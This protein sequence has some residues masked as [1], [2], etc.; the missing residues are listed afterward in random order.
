MRS[1]CL[2]SHGAA[3]DPLPHPSLFLNSFSAPFQADRDQRVAAAAEATAV[4]R[5]SFQEEI[6]RQRR[7]IEV[8]VADNLERLQVLYAPPKTVSAVVGPSSFLPSA[9]PPLF[10]AA[11][12]T[13]GFGAAGS[14]STP[15]ATGGVP[16]PRSAP[17]PE[18][19]KD[20]VEKLLALVRV[21]RNQ[22]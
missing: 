19:V 12:P 13:A 11:S 18:R 2:C 6:N 22:I 14:V 8:K 10:T 21:S 3:N 17:E 9:A 15:L 4:E 16:T 20:E 7:D 1:P 5:H